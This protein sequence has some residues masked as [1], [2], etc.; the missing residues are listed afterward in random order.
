VQEEAERAD[1]LAAAAHPP[2]VRSKR[3]VNRVLS[4]LNELAGED[5]S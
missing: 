3:E 1:E 2:A 5:E 4:I